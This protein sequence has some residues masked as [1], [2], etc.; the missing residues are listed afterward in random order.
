MMISQSQWNFF[1]KN[2]KHNKFKTVKKFYCITAVG[3]GIPGAL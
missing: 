1:G 2:S 3:V